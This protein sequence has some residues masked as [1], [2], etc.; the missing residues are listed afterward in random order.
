MVVFICLCV[1]MCDVYVH[2]RVCVCGLLCAFVCAYVSTYVSMFV[3]V[4][5]C[6]RV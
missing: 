3:C 6:V 5:R 1:Y 4:C 2:A